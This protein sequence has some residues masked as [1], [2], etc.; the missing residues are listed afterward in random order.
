MTTST[1]TC[2]KAFQITAYDSDNIA[3]GLLPMTCMLPGASAIQTA[4]EAYN[5]N[6]PHSAS[7]KTLLLTRKE[8]KA[9]LSTKH[10][11]YTIW[12]EAVI[13]LGAYRP[14]LGVLLCY[15]H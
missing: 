10:Q 13:Q 15:Q 6:T 8:P 4:E 9:V 14:L 2:L 1:V 3:G 12:I 5:V 11:R 7:F